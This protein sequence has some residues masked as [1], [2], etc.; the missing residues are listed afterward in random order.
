MEINED[1]KIEHGLRTTTL[2]NF[3]F[4]SCTIEKILN[5]LFGKYKIAT[6]KNNKSSKQTYF[7]NAAASHR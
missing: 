1:V 4:F 3:F 6:V 5:I 7:S 2:A